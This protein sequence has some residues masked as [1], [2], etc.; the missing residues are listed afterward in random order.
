MT[1]LQSIVASPAFPALAVLLPC[2][3]VVLLWALVEDLNDPSTRSYR[4][5]QRAHAGRV[6]ARRRGAR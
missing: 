4:A 3:L 5:R 2:L 6:K 1:L